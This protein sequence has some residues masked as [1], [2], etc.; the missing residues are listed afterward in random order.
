F[1]LLKN[2]EKNLPENLTKAIKKDEILS[3]S[4]KSINFIY[5]IIL[6]LCLYSL[7]KT[8]RRN[9]IVPN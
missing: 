4:F 3:S 6:G 2:Y 5:S 7:Q 1:K 9:S 8:A